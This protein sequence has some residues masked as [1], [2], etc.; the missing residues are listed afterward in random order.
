M[1]VYICRFHSQ[2]QI[3]TSWL[4]D[5]VTLRVQGAHFKAPEDPTFPVWSDPGEATGHGKATAKE[6][7][8]DC[9]YWLINERK[10]HTQAYV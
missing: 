4:R 8:C 7:L 10:A 1:F 2:R 5:D 6:V 3:M 9:H